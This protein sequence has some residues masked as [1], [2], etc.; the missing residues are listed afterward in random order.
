MNHSRGIGAAFV[1]GAF[2]CA[3][4]IG[5]GY[6]VSQGILQVKA[7]ERTVTVKGLAEREVAADVAIWPIRFTEAGNEL[8]VI[9]QTVQEHNGLVM[10]FLR[11]QGFG[12]AEISVS[13]PVMVDRQ[14]QGYP[15]TG[16]VKFRYAA[17]STISS[18]ISACRTGKSFS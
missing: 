16:E 12:D 8:V 11:R 6:L 14:A 3:G 15:N 7:L 13:A 10:D 5:L 17:T 18:W 2:I 4:L 9:Y 1:V